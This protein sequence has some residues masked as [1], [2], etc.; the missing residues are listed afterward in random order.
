[1]IFFWWDLKMQSSG[2]RISKAIFQTKDFQ[3]PFTTDK[4]MQNAIQDKLNLQDHFKNEVT[5]KLNNEKCI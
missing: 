5:D 2:L 1:M 3:I 4:M